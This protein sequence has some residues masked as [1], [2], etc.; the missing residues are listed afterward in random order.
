MAEMLRSLSAPISGHGMSHSRRTRLLEATGD[1]AS[2]LGHSVALRENVSEVLAEA[3]AVAELFDE[4]GAF[5]TSG[6]S[7]EAID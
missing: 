4:G 6:G 3:I 7:F 2:V 1:K 5:A